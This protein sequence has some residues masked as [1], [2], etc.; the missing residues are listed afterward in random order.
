MGARTWD[1]DEVTERRGEH[2]DDAAEHAERSDPLQKNYDKMLER[3]EVYAEEDDAGGKGNEYERARDV[4]AEAGEEGVDSLELG[5]QVGDER[6][7]CVSGV[8]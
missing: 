6:P 8:V 3:G 5:G 1:E 4:L 2:V 7:P